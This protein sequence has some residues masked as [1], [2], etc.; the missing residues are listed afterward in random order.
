MIGLLAGFLRRIV[1]T[2]HLEIVD[3]D[4]TRETFGDG[5][6][7][8][9]RVR[10]MDH[11]VARDL[12]IHP[13]LRLGEAYTDE[14]LV[15]EEGDV[16]DFLLLLLQSGAEDLPHWQAAL[17]RRLAIAG[18]RLAQFNPRGRAR[19]NVKH[20]YDLGDD[21]YALFLDGDWQYSCAYFER[22]DATIDEAQLAKKRHIAAKLALEPGQ[23]VLD[24]GCGWGG[25]GLYLARTAGVEV[26][27]ITLSDEQLAR[28]RRRAREAGLSDYAR[29]ELTDYR[30]VA[31]RFDRIVSVGMFEHVGVSHYGEYFEACRRLLAEDGVMLLHTIG[32]TGPPGA[33]N[34]FIAKY[35]FP[36]GYIPSLSEVMPAI[37]RL[38][39]VVTDVE[40]LRL[41]YA[42][43][44]KAWRE[45]FMANRAAAEA[46]HDARFC[47]M[48]EFYLAACE[49]S[50]RAGDF[51]V[52]QIQLARRVD[53]LPI[54]RGYMER[55]EEALRAAETAAGA[56]ARLRESA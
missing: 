31:G 53:A 2:G 19:R 8:P 56:P 36:G 20:H 40:M 55:A 54:T 24:I 28:A 38:G 46:L 50:F 3:A 22:P 23:R 25:L 34:P 11:K 43:T 45:R 1:R 37:E 9:V 30:D 27:G 41:H 6:G 44:L 39:L 47:R 17:R 7:R 42:E 52:F 4:G 15:L 26:T 35:I 10:F 14:R 49:A 16:H 21:L 32:R 18:R 33:T 29:F 51:V 12:L 5:T 48:W 13:H